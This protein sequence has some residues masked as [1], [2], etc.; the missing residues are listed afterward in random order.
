MAHAGGAD[1][2]AAA[3]SKSPPPDK[4]AAK[5]A[6]AQRTEA[7]NQ[8]LV[9]ARTAMAAR[10]LDDA[11]DQIQAAYDN[12]QTPAEKDE[13]ARVETLYNNLKEFWKLIRR[14]AGQLRAMDEIES[15]AAIA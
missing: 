3:A 2:P 7:R 8:A 10:N 9:A 1:K 13:V 6:L 14:R 15:V 4:P 11:R 5:D 12:A